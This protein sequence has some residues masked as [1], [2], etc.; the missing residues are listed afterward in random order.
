MGKR[1]RTKRH[2]DKMR[3]KRNAKAAKVAAYAQMRDNNQN[4][5][6]RR[7]PR[8]KRTL[9]NHPEGPCH[10]V[11]CSKCFTNEGGRLRPRADQ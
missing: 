7:G 8:M 3:A 5:K 10:N 11:G 1:A 2:I 4:H 6:Q 9:G